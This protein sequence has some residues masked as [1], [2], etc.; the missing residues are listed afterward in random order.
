VTFLR[1]LTAKP[2]SLLKNLL[3][4][5]EMLLIVLKMSP[6]VNRLQTFSTGWTVFER[7][8]RRNAA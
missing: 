1:S 6:T 4:G 2:T 3:Q 5:S 7:K 8:S